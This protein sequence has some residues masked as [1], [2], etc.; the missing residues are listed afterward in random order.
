MLH[1]QS[2]ESGKETRVYFDDLILFYASNTSYLS[3]MI[4][5]TIIG[6]GTSMLQILQI[7]VTCT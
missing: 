4:F 7:S 1:K 6:L 3:P 5:L 2:D